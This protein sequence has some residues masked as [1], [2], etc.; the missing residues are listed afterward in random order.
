MGACMNSNKNT[1]RGVTGECTNS[2]NKLYGVGKDNQRIPIKH[3][4]VAGW[5]LE[6]LIGNAT[7]FGLIGRESSSIFHAVY[8]FMQCHYTKPAVLWDAVKEELRAGRMSIRRSDSQ[9]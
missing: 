4:G 5:V 2:N 9:W 6:V 7:F 1:Q 8:A 3:Q